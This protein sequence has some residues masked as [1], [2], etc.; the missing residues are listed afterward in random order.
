MSSVFAADRTQGSAPNQ[1]NSKYVL[2]ALCVLSTAR[3]VAVEIK[4]ERHSLCASA[5][6][7]LWDTLQFSSPGSSAPGILS[8]GKNTGVV[9]VSSSRGSSRPRDQTPVSRLAGGIFTS[10]PPE[11]P[12]PP[13]SML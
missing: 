7:P 9:A 3:G 12:V 1:L 4:S 13:F 11:K 8:P 10:E 5:A 6:L 2:T